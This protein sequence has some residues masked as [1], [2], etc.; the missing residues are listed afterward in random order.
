MSGIHIQVFR[1][2][3]KIWVYRLAD[4]YKVLTFS[5]EFGSGIEVQVLR[6]SIGVQVLRFRYVG[7]VFS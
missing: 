5:S 4:K 3:I 7:S 2:R 1:F 6:S